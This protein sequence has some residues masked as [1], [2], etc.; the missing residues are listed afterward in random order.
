MQRN[1]VSLSPV[2]TPNLGEPD[3]V[4]VDQFEFEPGDRFVYTYNYFSNHVHDI[5]VESI[6]QVDESHWTPV[7]MGGK[8]L[9]DIDAWS[10]RVRIHMLFANV[11]A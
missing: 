3:D 9:T 7:C 5:R 4:H 8:R 2:A 11:Q 10:C 6:D 1:T